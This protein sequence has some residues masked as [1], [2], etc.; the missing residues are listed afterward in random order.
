MTVDER[1]DA[2]ERTIEQQQK[3][4]QEIRSSLALKIAPSIPPQELVDL[5]NSNDWP[6]AVDPSLICDANSDQD[7]EDRAEG[8]LDLI[9]DVHLE[10]LKFLDFGCGEGHVVN[11]SR[12]QKPKISVGYDVQEFDKWKSW[13]K[14]DAAIY[15]TNW[16]EVKT[17]APYNVVLVYDVID[18]MTCSYEKLV[19]RLKTIKEMLATNGKVFVRCHPWCSRHG[20]H[21]YQK[22]NKAYVHMVF[23]DHELEKLGY[24]QEKTRKVI[25]P[26]HEYGQLF[27]AAGLKIVSGPFQVIEKPEPFFSN[28][29]LIAARIK[30]K[31]NNSH[32]E[33][34]KSGKEF[35]VFPM[36]N[37]FVD[38][39]LM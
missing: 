32:W 29:P 11:R 4:I 22:L 7:K 36:E 25:H 23:S 1:L 13:E 26:L 27:A 21:L 30:A 37:Q 38:Y 39:V 6:T 8:I 20:T 12:T 33:T 19:E 31:Y 24:I 5:L 18:H 2:L 17:L 14:D 9:I 34:L 3:E 15:T 10:N 35:P 16:D 28:N